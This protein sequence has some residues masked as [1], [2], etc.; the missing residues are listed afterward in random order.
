MQLRSEQQ[1]ARIALAC[2]DLTSL[3][4]NDDEAAIDALCRKARTPWGNVAAVC[5][6]PRLAAH[7]RQQLPPQIQVAAVANFPHGS[8][9]VSSV[10]TDV[11]TILNA[12]AQEIDVVLPY[13]QLLAG[14]V[15]AVERLLRAVRE[16]SPGMRLKVILETGIL[17]TP[18][19]ITLAAE[20]GLDCGADF[21]KTS[22]GKTPVSATEQAARCIL[23]SIAKRGLIAAS[24]GFK[25][26]GGIRKVADAAVYMRLQEEFLGVGSLQP[27]RFRIGASSILDNIASILVASPQ[28][29]LAPMHSGRDRREDLY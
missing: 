5:V 14:D 15:Q 29:P 27:Q 9:D 4:D 13:R 7:A 2:L 28:G 23:T 18:K 26:S 25:P 24:L 6:W 10:L 8:S 19:L 11:R 16:A 20:I 12:G 17:A 22:T 3:N 21:L 1:Q